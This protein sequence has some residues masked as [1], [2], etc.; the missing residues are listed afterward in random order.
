MKCQIFKPWTIEGDRIVVHALD[1][2][3]GL[4]VCETCRGR[5]VFWS[6]YDGEEYGP[7]GTCKDCDGTGSQSVAFGCD[8]FGM[9]D[10][11]RAVVSDVGPTGH[12]AK[13]HTVTSSDGTVRPM[14]PA[15]L[16]RIAFGWMD[17][18]LSQTSGYAKVI[19]GESTE[20]IHWLLPTEHPERVRELWPRWE[21]GWGVGNHRPNVTLCLVVRTQGDAEKLSPSRDLK[22]LCNVGIWF[23]N[24]QR[25]IEYPPHVPMDCVILDPRNANPEALADVR[26]QA[27]E[28]GI[29]IIELEI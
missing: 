20:P 21:N 25:C 7:T 5:G 1:L 14:F 23:N 22:D 15:D 12:A 24:Q 2:P 26:R 13:T 29:S 19:R 10:L 3:D 8:L 9:G 11:L 6:K 27:S 17:S 16:L 28:S 4:G 18:R